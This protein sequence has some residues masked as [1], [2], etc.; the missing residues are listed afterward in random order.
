MVASPARTTRF[1]DVLER[2][3]KHYPYVLADNVRE[4]TALAGLEH[5]ARA[6]VRELLPEKR[7]WST[8]EF[9]AFEGE[10]FAEAVAL[11]L[12]GRPATDAESAQFVDNNHPVSRFTHLVAQYHL[13]RK[14]GTSLRIVGLE[15]LLRLYRMQR[16]LQRNRLGP[17]GRAVGQIFHR[18]ARRLER[19]LIDHVVLLQATHTLL[20]HRTTPDD[21]ETDR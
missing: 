10:D 21:T 1:R 11:V 16:F 3:A 13:A 8:S 15:R 18:K 20:R 4:T 19:H 9:L 6:S 14:R 2:H 12:A 7:V 5:R 17:L